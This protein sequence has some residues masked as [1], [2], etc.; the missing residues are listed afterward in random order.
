[1]EDVIALTDKD[2]FPTDDVLRRLLGKSYPAYSALLDLFSTFKMDNEWRYYKDGKAWLCKV[3]YKKRTIL[4]MSAWRGYMKA[5]AYFPEK[6][7]KGLYSLAIDEEFKQRIKGTKNIGKLKPCTF[8]I[9]G[10]KVLK[11]LEGIIRFKIEAK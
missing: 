10:K 11:D 4:W 8:E 7:L 1:M 5:T 2:V 3:Q 9:R 6:H